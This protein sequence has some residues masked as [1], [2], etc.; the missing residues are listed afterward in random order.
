MYNTLEGYNKSKVQA[1]KKKGGKGSK[2]RKKKITK[3]SSSASLGLG[4]SSSSSVRINKLTLA[5]VIFVTVVFINI[6][7]CI[8]FWV[9]LDL[10]KTVGNASEL[11]EVSMTI[12]SNLMGFYSVF[13]SQLYNN[14]QGK[15]ITPKEKNL[16]SKFMA[17]IQRREGLQSMIFNY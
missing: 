10:A 5:L 4:E 17:I 6:P 12:G 7:L 3:N 16:N 2:K 9:V 14:Y 8:D 15:V 13:Y 11:F 1:S